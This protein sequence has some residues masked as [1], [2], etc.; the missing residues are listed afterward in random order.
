[1]HVNAMHKFDAHI[2]ISVPKG[3]HKLKSEYKNILA[4]MARFPVRSD[5]L[6]AR[7]K[8]SVLDKDLERIEEGIRTYEK[9][10]VFVLKGGDGGIE[11]P[12]E[13]VILIENNSSLT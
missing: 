13:Q 4:E 3:L 1:M 9:Q 7:Q 2:Q 5:T 6:R 12:Y 10:K 11:A 8:R